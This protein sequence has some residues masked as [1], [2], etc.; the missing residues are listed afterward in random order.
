MQQVFWQ[1]ILSRGSHS[2]LLV[3]ILDIRLSPSFGIDFKGRK[4][5]AF[6]PPNMKMSSIHSA[7]IGPLVP[8]FLLADAEKIIGDVCTGFM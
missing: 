3:L 5:T 8:E 2:D 1:V 6:G 4:I 7:D